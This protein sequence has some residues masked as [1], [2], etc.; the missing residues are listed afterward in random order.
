MPIKFD[1]A[2]IG[3]IQQANDIVD[4]VSEH[5]RL[6]KK[7]RELAGL[8]PF[9]D[10]HRPS[11]GVNPEKQIFKCFACGAGGDVIKFVQMKE[12]LSFVQALE[13]LAERAGI[14]LEQI[15]RADRPAGTLDNAALGRLNE[16]ACKI[17]QENL[18]DKTRGAQAR[19][20]LQ[21]RGITE[22]T[23]KD[24]RLGLAMESWDDLCSK[25]KKAGIADS[26]IEQAGLA[27]KKE[28]GGCYDKFRNRLMFAIVDVAGRVIGFGGRTLADEPAK[29]MNSPTTGLFDK[30]RCMYGLDK[31]RHSIVQQ[32]RTVVVEGYTDVL[33]AHQFGITN[34][35]ASLGTSLT[36]G[37]C[38]LLRR[39]ASQVVLVFDSDIAGRAAAE[40]ALQV[41]LAEKVD[42][43]LTFAPEGKDPC[44][45]LQSCG[46]EAF[47]GILERAEDVVEYAWKTALERLSG[48]E[49][50]AGRTQIIE[51]FLQTVASAIY[52]EQA[53][54]LSGGVLI[55]RLSDLTGMSY[56]RIEQELSRMVKQKQKSPGAAAQT[57]TQD[58]HT[59]SFEQAQREALEVLLN[60][61]GLYAGYAGQI[62]PDMFTGKMKPI[63][64]ALFD[65]LKD[66]A[67]PTI[68]EVLGRVEDAESAK[69]LTD[70]EQQ[71]R[72]KGNFQARLDQACRTL[73][74]GLL[75]QQTRRLKESLDT[76]SLTQIQALL[77]QRGK[78]QRN[79][80][81]TE[82]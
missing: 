52:A 39:Y 72:E 81:F 16:W 56:G 31:A 14:R 79:P 27:V 66:G 65:F 9:H 77:A 55:G 51:G 78:N 40:R 57:Q 62:Q 21:K 76:E 47:S 30:S 63:A 7:G 34:V 44:E 5:L 82:S 28:Q 45:Y 22:S 32:K 70:M 49:S 17:W 64:D 23:A 68:T 54:D 25:A 29:Y 59:D 24:W 36:S 46:A 8:C 3:R 26:A 48:K 20:Y 43:R 74:S 11:L 61:P 71:G 2:L 19:E 15:R 73:N 69:L 33:M 18:W 38:R 10:D 6:V 37:H 1:S 42:I 60:E 50:V 58:S 12:G 80:G 53:E 13:R 35:V 41:C 4:V 67:E 75:G